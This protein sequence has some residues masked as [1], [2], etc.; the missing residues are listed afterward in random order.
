MGG[1][2]EVAAEPATGGGTRDDRRRGTV[3]DRAIA[4]G[5]RAEVA[6]EPATGGNARRHAKG[7]CCG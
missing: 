4:W 5:A 3:N 1:R 7:Y 2:A 6:A